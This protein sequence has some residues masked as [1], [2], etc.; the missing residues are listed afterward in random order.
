ML[1][2]I[3]GSGFEKFEDFET[4]EILNRET[5]FGLAASGFKKVRVEGKEFLFI[6]RHGEHHEHLPSEI[7]YRANIFA[8]KKMGVKAIVS[9]S[10]VGSLQKEFAPGDC[11]VPFQYIDRTKSLRQHTFLGQGLIGHVSLAKP[12]CEVMAAHAQE[13]V[14]KL[15]FK[16]HFGQTYVCIEGPYFSTKAESNFYRQMGAQIVG[17]S[18]FPEYALAREAGLPYLPCCFVTDYDCW[19]DSIP[20]VTVEEVIKVMRGNNAKAFAILKTILKLENI[21]QESLAYNGGLKT[22]L[23]MPMEAIPKDKKSWVEILM[24]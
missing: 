17:M 11:V 5:P 4:V 21:A 16:T 18:N 6:S 13:S 9:F 1:G 14:Q 15:N 8:F 24:K 7:N 19:D 20:H 2:I 23:F 12:I 10:A 3:G 22:G